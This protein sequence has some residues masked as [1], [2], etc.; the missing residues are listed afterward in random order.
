[1]RQIQEHNKK[2][3]I[4]MPRFDVGDFVL[5]RK[6]DKKGHELIFNWKGPKRTTGTVNSLVYEVTGLID[7]KSDSVHASRL[8][9]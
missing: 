1:M 7:E 5:V 3:N 8:T 4:V 6:P 2:T 9:L